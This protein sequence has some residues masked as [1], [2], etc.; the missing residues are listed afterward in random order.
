[1]NLLKT[2]I[3]FSLITA[4]QFAPIKKLMLPLKNF[5]FQGDV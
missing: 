1:M 5:D 3:Y 4:A 2:N